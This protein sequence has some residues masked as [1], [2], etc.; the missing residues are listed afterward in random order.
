MSRFAIRLLT[1]AAFSMALA[2]RPVIT[3]VYAAPDNDAPAPSTAT[4]GKK[5]EVQ[6]SGDRPRVCGV[7]RR[8]PRRLCH[9]L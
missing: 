3:S 7:R 9:D 1:L 4:K 5:E 6:R 8:L 2:T